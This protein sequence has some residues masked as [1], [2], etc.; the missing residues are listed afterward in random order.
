MV[1]LQF[2]FWLLYTFFT[3]AL[4]FQQPIADTKPV[5]IIQKN[6][7]NWQNKDL[8]VTKEK[9]T[10]EITPK[11]VK[12]KSNDKLTPAAKA[13]IEIKEKKEK[14]TMKPTVATTPT[15]IN[16]LEEIKK[17]RATK[18]VDPPTVSLVNSIEKKST[19]KKK[20]AAAKADSD[21]K[22]QEVIAKWRSKSDDVEMAVPLVSG[23][24]KKEYIFKSEAKTKKEN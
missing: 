19:I 20:E 10:V 22:Q 9:P 14:A 17:K 7:E 16:I 5:K 6:I 23:K 3:H 2:T 24:R 15:A 13:I 8:Q 11:V 21:K 12:K 4:S 1:L 18:I